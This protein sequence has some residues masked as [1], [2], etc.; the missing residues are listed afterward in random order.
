M[1]RIRASTGARS[2]KRGRRSANLALAPLT[3]LGE[4]RE[5]DADEQRADDHD[6]QRRFAFDEDP[7]DL[8]LFNIEHGEQCHQHRQQHES[9]GAGQL[10]PAATALRCLGGIRHRQRDAT[11]W[12]HQRNLG[13]VGRQLGQHPVTAGRQFGDAHGGGHVEGHAVAEKIV[14]TL[15]LGA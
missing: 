9:P 1:C 4:V 13:L 2:N 12:I 6:D 14:E 8:D 15:G 5:Q 11:R 7:V 3:Q 10:T